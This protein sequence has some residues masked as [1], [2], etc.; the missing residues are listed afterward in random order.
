MYVYMHM[1]YIYILYMYMF[2]YVH[3]YV[4]IYI[5]VYVC[6][7]LYMYI[8][9][10]EIRGYIY[11]YVCI[12]LYMYIYT[13]EFRGHFARSPTPDIHIDIPLIGSNGI[14]TYIYKRQGT[15]HGVGLR[16]RND[17]RAAPQQQLRP[18]P[19]GE[20]FFEKKI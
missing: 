9:T 17:A 8:Y 19:R 4:Y 14:H 10:S 12:Y 18:S 2:I 5:Y 7:Y 3:I 13:S 20:F 6:I 16:A 11:V 1:Y 15:R